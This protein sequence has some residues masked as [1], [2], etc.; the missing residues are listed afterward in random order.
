M[1]IL[2]KNFETDADKKKIAELL[3]VLESQKEP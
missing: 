2:K 3:L 1:A